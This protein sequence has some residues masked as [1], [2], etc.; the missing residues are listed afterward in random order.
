MDI[1][2][3]CVGS[4]KLNLSYYDGYLH[5]QQSLNVTTECYEKKLSTKV[6]NICKI[7]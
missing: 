5:G 3:T 1:I 2:K 7:K 6:T 4:F